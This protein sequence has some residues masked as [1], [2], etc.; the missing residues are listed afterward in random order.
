MKN[1]FILFLLVL[2]VKGLFG[3]APESFSY[4][5]SVVDDTGQPLAN[6]TVSFRFSIVKGGVVGDVV[7][8]ERHVV[9]TNL[10][11]LVN[12]AIGNGTILSGN[13]E[14][15]D[16]GADSYFLKV[17]LDTA[18][19][20]FY[21]DMGTTQFLSVPYALHAKTSEDSFSGDYNDLANKPIT[22]GSETKIEAGVNIIVHGIGTN[23]DPYTISSETH[24]I[25]GDNILVDGSGTDT[26]P[27]IINER[28]HQTGDFYGGGIVFYVY[29]NG[30]HGLIA[31]TRD[32]DP[33]IGWSNGV[34]RYTN[35]TG[36]GVGSGDM[37]TN[38]IIALQTNDNQYGNFAAKVCADYSVT[39]NGVTYG[40]WYLPSKNELDLL[41]LQMSV[42]GGFTSEYYWSSTEFSSISAWCQNWYNGL[43][44]NMNKSSKYGVRAIRAF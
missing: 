40:D 42:V 19:G 26:N 18:G 32:Q 14:T 39:V 21:V 25:A 4:K 37:N 13:F 44:F 38:M 10:Y 1:V 8:G 31:A 12:L 33:A 41:F 17:E 35:T 27:Y 3:Q 16:W 22:D 5:A 9:S 2:C 24:V 20:T 30:R 29:D 28:I 36:D 15:I 23:S 34:M 11:G 6:Q 43:Q 7:Y